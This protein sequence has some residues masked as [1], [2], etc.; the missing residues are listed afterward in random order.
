MQ[1]DVKAIGAEIAGVVFESLE[2]VLKRIKDLEARQPEKGPPGDP[3]K[4]GKDCDKTWVE[5]IVAAQFALLSENIRATTRS[6]ESDL[7]KAQQIAR[8]SAERIK[9][10]ID[11]IS[12]KYAAQEKARINLATRISAL[13]GQQIEID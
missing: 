10:E 3:G 5:S 2:P 11:E 13:L 8:R 9:A 4:D 12:A 1:L 6:M 7:E